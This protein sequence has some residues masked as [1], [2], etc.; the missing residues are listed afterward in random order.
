MAAKTYRLRIGSDGKEF[1]AEGDKVFVLAMAK[2]YGPD[3]SPNLARVPKGGTKQVAGKQSSL[4][5]TSPGKG[6]SIR[7]FV[8]QLDLKKHT[9]ISLAFGYYLEKHGGKND[10]S[11]SDLNNCYY[12]AKME[13]SNTSQMIAQNIKTGRMMPSKEKG[14]KGRLRFTLTNSGEEF[15]AKKL[16]KTV[17]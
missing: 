13:A 10:F 14:D 12:D 8:Q 3:T 1:E 2:L 16:T 15:I 5:V 9:D 17:E 6:V 4:A 7:E 11:A